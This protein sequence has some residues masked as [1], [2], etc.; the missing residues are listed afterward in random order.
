VADLEEQQNDCYGQRY[1]DCDDS[2]GRSAALASATKPSAVA[3]GYIPEVPGELFQ[4][5]GVPRIVFSV[6]HRNQL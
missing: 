6:I 5:P 4:D 1:D 3:S 2:A